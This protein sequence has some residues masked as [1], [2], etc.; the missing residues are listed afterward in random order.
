MDLDYALGYIILITSL[1]IPFIYLAGRRSPRIAAALLLLTYLLGLAL[2]YSVVGEVTL[3]GYHIERYTWIPVLGTTFTLFVDGIGVSMA[4]MTLCLLIAVIPF[5]LG[6]MDGE[7]GLGTYFAFLSLLTIGLVG[8]FI[9]SCLLAFYFFWEL[10]LIPTYFLI[11]RWGYRK[12]EEV[13]FKFFIFTH[14]GAVFVLIGIGAI[15]MLTGTLDI[16]QAQKLLLDSPPDILWWVLAFFTIG[17]SVKM[18]TVPVHMWLPDAHA[19]APA[20]ISALL[21]GVII[22]A[23]AYAILRISLQTV[24]PALPMVGAGTTFLHILCGFGVLSAFYGAFNALAENDVKR[25]IAYSS[26]SHMGYVLFGLSL[27]SSPI[28]LIG[29]VFH[30]LAHMTSKGLLFLTA[31]IVM[32]QTGLRD[33]REMGGLGGKMPLTVTSFAVSAF[34]IAGMPP[35]ACFVSEFML[36]TG[37]FHA[38][39]RD[40]FFLWSTALA[41]L[42]TVLSTGYVLRLFWRVFLG[43]PKNGS[44]PKPSLWM[45]LPSL[46]LALSI[47]Y[48]GVYPRLFV[49]LIAGSLSG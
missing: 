45:T 20:P 28:G 1:S 41:V 49:E 32:K 19:E 15:F 47:I 27:S 38:A 46:A 42:A 33:I 35:L 34:S 11:A 4:A 18:A 36:F 30:L 8:V 2:L 9:T 44:V 23:G 12:P 17:F 48:L 21:S 13:A 43:E 24:L 16:L 26:I 3:S 5:S 29:T 37:G 6:Y 10:M 39:S 25:V 14:A 40:P 22:E 31:G 7:E